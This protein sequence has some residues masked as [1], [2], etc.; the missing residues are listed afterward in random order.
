GLGVGSD[1]AAGRLRARTGGPAQL[2]GAGALRAAPRPARSARGRSARGR[3]EARGLRR[4]GAA[5]RTGFPDRL[6]GLRRAPGR[7]PSA[8]DGAGEKAAAEGWQAARR[9]PGPRAPRGT[10]PAE[11]SERSYSNTLSTGTIWTS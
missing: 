9:R 2:R 6:P 11:L 3:L 8:G 10:R 7:N 5:A 1:P 4:A